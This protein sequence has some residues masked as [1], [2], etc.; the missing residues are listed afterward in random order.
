M[1]LG[2]PVLMM[3]GSDQALGVRG[4]SVRQELGQSVSDQ[5]VVG[6]TY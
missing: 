1:E 2:V 4:V 3:R 5:G 6:Q